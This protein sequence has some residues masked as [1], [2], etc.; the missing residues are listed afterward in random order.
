MKKILNKPADFVDEMVE[1]IL[2][3]HPDQ[4]KTPGDDLRIMVPCRRSRFGK[5]RDRHRRRFGAPSLV[6]RLC[7]QRVVR[8][9]RHRQC[10]QF[11]ELTAV[12][13]GHRR[14]ERWRR[15]AL[16]LRQLRR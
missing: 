15:S 1:G 16:S 11:A 10:L 5:G 13:R 6:Q 2:L 9:S 12:F 14:S 3:A 8:R 4:L 7:G